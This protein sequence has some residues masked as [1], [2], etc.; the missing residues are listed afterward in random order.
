MPAK[1]KATAVWEHDLVKGSGTVQGASGAIPILPVTWVARTEQ[2]GGKTSPE[3][4]LAAAHASCFAMAFSATLGRDQHPPEKLTVT[5]EA[6]FDKVGEAWKVTTM[7]L[8]VV[9]KVPGIDA[10]KFSELAA[11]A[12]KG[13]PISNAIRNNV[14]VRVHARLG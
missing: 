2:S 7:D 3:E 14:D 11:T 10:A 13:C 8:E 6:T 5:A 9:G 12:E 4:L 1:R